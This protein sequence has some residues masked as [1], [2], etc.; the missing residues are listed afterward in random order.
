MLYS[1]GSSAWCSA[2]AVTI[3]PASLKEYF[4]PDLLTADLLQVSDTAPR[5]L[6]HRCESLGRV[7]ICK[8]APLFS[9]M[10]ISAALQWKQRGPQ[11]S[12]TWGL[13]LGT[14]PLRARDEGLGQ[15]PALGMM[16]QAPPAKSQPGTYSQALTAVTTPS[17]KVKVPCA[18]SK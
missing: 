6:N 2:P 16:G 1:T 14:R 18:H 10:A 4:P 7:Q 15:L 13:V 3:G 9:V 17:E 11:S 12:T 8:R 5:S